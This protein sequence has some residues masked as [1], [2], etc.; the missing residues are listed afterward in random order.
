[1]L[2]NAIGHFISPIMLPNNPL[3]MLPVIPA[4]LSNVLAN[5][6]SAGAPDNL[7]NNLSGI[8]PVMPVTFLN[9]LLNILGAAAPDML[10]NK[11]FDNVAPEI[12]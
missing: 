4:Q 6:S 12:C 1:M 2:L 8:E 10:P 11:L 3:G 7:P 9:V 5:I